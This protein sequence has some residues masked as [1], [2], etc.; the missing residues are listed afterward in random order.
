MTNQGNSGGKAT[1]ATHAGAGTGWDAGGGGGGARDG[2]DKCDS[3]QA[4]TDIAQPGDGGAGYT[5]GRHSV[6]DW[7]AGSGTSLFVINGLG[8][9]FC[10]GGSGASQIT[11]VGVGQVRKMVHGLATHGGGTGGIGYTGKGRGEDAINYTG[12]GGGGAGAGSVITGDG[13]HGIV[14][15]RYTL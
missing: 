7:T 12:G 6:Y 9:G 5:E 14:I 8:E 15:V 13:G 10:G 1:G 2:G 3:P 11:D 4:N